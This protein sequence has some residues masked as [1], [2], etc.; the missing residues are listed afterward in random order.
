VLGDV[1]AA[2]EWASRARSKFPADARFR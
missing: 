1:A 2:R